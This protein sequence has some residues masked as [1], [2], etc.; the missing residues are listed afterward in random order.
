MGEGP[1]RGPPKS[2]RR[3]WILHLFFGSLGISSTLSLA[4]PHVDTVPPSRSNALVVRPQKVIRKAPE[5]TGAEF[6]CW[7]KWRSSQEQ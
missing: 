2:G 6:P 1:H 3:S 7:S 5:V 4:K